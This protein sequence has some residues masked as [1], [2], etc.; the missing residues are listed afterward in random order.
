MAT[1]MSFLMKTLRSPSVTTTLLITTIIIYLFFVHRDLTS[2]QRYILELKAQVD[3]IQH[4]LMSDR[5]NG[6]ASQTDA[7]VQVT[8]D[9]LNNGSVVNDDAA[10]ISSDDFANMLDMIARTDADTLAPITEQEEQEEQQEQEEQGERE[11]QDLEPA[12]DEAGFPQNI[13]D[14]TVAQLRA[15]LKLHGIDARGSKD[16]LVAKAKAYIEQPAS[17]VAHEAAA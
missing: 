2:H 13:E 12:A 7:E 3:V 15:F 16:K 4:V 1:M 17:D 5:Q 8:D 6:H 10:S 14:A 9:A 11:A